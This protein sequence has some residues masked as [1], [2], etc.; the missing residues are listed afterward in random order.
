MFGLILLRFQ[1]DL[2]DVITSP[3]GESIDRDTDPAI[4]EIDPLLGVVELRRFQELVPYPEAILTLVKPDYRM[5]S[6]YPGAW[7]MMR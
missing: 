1:T 2:Q 6:M 4:T 5:L 3:L 7:R